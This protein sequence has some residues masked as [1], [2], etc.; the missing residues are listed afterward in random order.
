MFATAPVENIAFD[1][2][3][4]CQVNRDVA[5]VVKGLIQCL[6]TFGGT[7]QFEDQALQRIRLMRLLRYGGI[8]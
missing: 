3:P 4:V 5:A 7:L 1:D 6:L 2:L 8:V